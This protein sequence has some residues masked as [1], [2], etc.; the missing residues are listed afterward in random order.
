MD[1]APNPV[2][3]EVQISVGNLSETGGMLSVFDAQGRMM[4][5]Q[6]IEPETVTNAADWQARIDLDGGW[7]SGIYMVALHTEG[8]TVTRRL[9]VSRL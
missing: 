7:K 6:R 2:V 3:N 5:L 1:I 9:V 8:Q 4:W